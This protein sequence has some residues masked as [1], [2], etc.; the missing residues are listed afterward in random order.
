[1]PT[2]H[3]GCTAYYSARTATKCSRL[4]L[5]HKD[6]QP[7]N[8]AVPIS[9]ESQDEEKKKFKI[10]SFPELQAKLPFVSKDNTWSTWHP[11]E[12]KLIIMCPHIDIYIR[13]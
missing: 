12:Y 4:Y 2:I 3:P 10:Q 11:D 1:M 9:L 6:D 13:Q 5:E 7:L 8:Q